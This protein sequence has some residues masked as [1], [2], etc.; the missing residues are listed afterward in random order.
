MFTILNNNNKKTLGDDH[1]LSLKN[2]AGEIKPVWSMKNPHR[3][4]YLQISL[5]FNKAL[6]YGN[7]H[8]Q[9]KMKN[10][11]REAE[12]ESARGHT[13]SAKHFF[14]SRKEIW[15][16]RKYPRGS[17]CYCKTGGGWRSDP[18]EEHWRDGNEVALFG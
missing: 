8:S 7:K 10:R 5:S 14:S 11:E 15:E 6:S 1:P 12:T 13:E 3:T 2:V 17:H 9:R 4:C 16:S 18:R